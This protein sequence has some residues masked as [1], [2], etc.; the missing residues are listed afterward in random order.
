MCIWCCGFV[1]KNDAFI[2]VYHFAKYFLEICDLQ[3]LELNIV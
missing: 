2:T 3:L 1:R